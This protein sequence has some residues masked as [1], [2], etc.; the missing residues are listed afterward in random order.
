[1][2]KLIYCAAPSRLAEHI[3][4]IMDFVTN[5]GL[6][7][8]HPFQAFPFKRYEGNPRV[9]RVKSMEYCL[10]AVRM[11]DELWMFGVS[12]G[13]LK[14]VKE[15]LKIGK[16]IQLHFEDWKPGDLEWRKQYKELG[17][18]YNNPIDNLLKIA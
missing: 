17:P 1:M 8:F 4:S 2:T 6:A 15:A 10:R 14:E 13:T 3:K 12:D 16:P 7:P 11:A 18:I 9:G 5:K